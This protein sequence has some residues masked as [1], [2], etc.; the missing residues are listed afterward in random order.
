MSDQA[1][2]VWRQPAPVT[3]PS[4]YE[5]A[6]WGSRFFAWMIDLIIVLS[7]LGIAKV[8]GLI[9]AASGSKAG[10]GIASLALPLLL[11]TI[12]C[13]PLTMTRKGSRN[14]QTWGKQLVGIRVVR[15][16][17]EPFGAGA[18]ML[19]ESVIKFIVFDWLG[20]IIVFIPFLLNYLSPLWDPQNRA[21]HDRMASSHVVSAGS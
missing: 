11:L 7:P 17:G 5:L 16:T 18:S 13:Y 19:R 15:D 12:V 10:L 21:L 9:F 3:L 6:P 8:G 14:G 2:R 4:G 1:A 20:I